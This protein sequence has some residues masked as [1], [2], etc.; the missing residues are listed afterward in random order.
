MCVLG[1]REQFF[2]DCQEKK[3][4]RKMLIKTI[5]TTDNFISGNYKVTMILAKHFD[6]TGLPI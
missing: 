5:A 3:G 1:V 2:S 6:P 4:K